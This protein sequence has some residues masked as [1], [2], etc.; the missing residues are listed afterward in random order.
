M[1]LHPVYVFLQGFVALY[2]IAMAFPSVSLDLYSRSPLSPRSPHVWDNPRHPSERSTCLLNHSQNDIPYIS[3]AFESNNANPTVTPAPILE[4][5]NDPSQPATQHLDI[6]QPSID[7]ESPSVPLDTLSKS[8]N[9]ATISNGVCLLAVAILLGAAGTRVLYKLYKFSNQP[10]RGGCKADSSKTAWCSRLFSSPTVKDEHND[11][12]AT[13]QS[14]SQTDR[15]GMS[16]RPCESDIL[17]RFTEPA[18][19]AAI[20]EPSPQGEVNTAFFEQPTI[21]R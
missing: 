13:A 5:Q 9:S 19:S 11:I 20:P 3:E 14:V 1:N 6:I 21:H 10:R 2:L 7:L 12:E 8:S 18:A 17:Q 16:T 15:F 4:L